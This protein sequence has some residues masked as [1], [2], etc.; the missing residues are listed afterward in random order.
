[1]SSLKYFR[2]QPNE[3]NY[4][5]SIRYIKQDHQFEGQKGVVMVTILKKLDTK[6]TTNRLAKALF[7]WRLMTSSFTEKVRASQS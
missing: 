2:S 7:V 6:S 5:T 3:L 1:M 4:S